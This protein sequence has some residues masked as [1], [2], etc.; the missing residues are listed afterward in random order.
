MSERVLIV[1]PERSALR[2]LEG[3]LEQ[4]GVG[5]VIGVDDPARALEAVAEHDPQ[6]VLLAIDGDGG[7]DSLATLA[8]WT[9]G[10]AQLPVVAMSASGSADQRRRAREAGAREFLAKPLDPTEVIARVENVLASA[11]VSARLAADRA[12]WLERVARLAEYRDDATYEHP[13]RVGRTA[14]LLAARLGLDAETVDLI[15]HAAPLHD[16]GK[17][18]VP[19]RILLKPGKLTGPEF[20]LMKMHTT[21][22]AEILSGSEWPVLQMAEQIA[23]THHERYDGTGYPRGLEGEAIP[24]PGRIVI[25]ADNF[26][27]LTH[28][29]PY[30]EAWDPERAAA[31]VRRMSARQFDPRVVEAFEGLD[32]NSLLAPVV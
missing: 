11:R 26:D 25:V 20:E 5:E 28:T 4:A 23:L 12:E 27:A 3:V 19:D 8:P 1:E 30:A 22:G 16:L 24:L 15:R 18:A 21:I 2:V 10:K 29:R 13:Q 7:L 14:A 6:L 17:V 32:L 31:E 9:G